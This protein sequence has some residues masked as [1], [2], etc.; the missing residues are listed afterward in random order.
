MLAVMLVSTCPLAGQSISYFV[1]SATGLDA[2]DGRSLATPWQTLANVNAR[3]FQPGDSILFKSGSSW[4]G[5]L[6][7]KG[8]GTAG[9]P[10]VIDMYGGTTKPLIAGNGIVSTG[11]L[12]LLNQE[13]WE[14][15]N[16]EVT[17]DAAVGGDR[18]G[19]YV[20]ASEFGIVHHI[21]LKK[22]DVHDVKGLVGD[23]DAEKRTAGIGFETTSDVTVPTRFD[24]LLIEGCN[25][26]MIDNTGIF[27]DNKMSGARTDYP[28]TGKWPA[29]KFTN[30]R[31][32]GNTIHHIAKN[33][34]IMRFLEQGVVEN[35]V[36]FE[37][38]LKT[39]GNTMFTASCDGTVFQ[40]NEG[41]YNRSVGADGSMYDAD[42]RSP[43]TI[44]QYSYSHDNAHGLFWTCTVQEDAN[45][46]CRYNV[47]QNDKG[48]IFCINYPNTSVACYNNTVYCGSGVS[49]TIISERNV[50]TGTRSYTFQ[51]NV[52]YNFS[53]TAK[54]DFR[55][56]GYTRVIDYNV[57]F[58][59]HPSNEP[60]DAHKLTSDPQFVNPGAAST[61]IS[62]TDG[63][64]LK[65]TSPCINSGF[66]VLA[67]GG[68]DFWG[69]SVPSGPGTDRGAHEFTTTSVG[70]FDESI[71]RTYQLA[72]NYPNPFNPDTN[73]RFQLAS[74]QHV[75][76][77][78]FDILGRKVR[79]LKYGVETVG[80]HTAQWDGNDD[81]GARVSSGVYLA[82][83]VA[84]SSVSITKMILSR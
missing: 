46:I 28:Q 57:F 75:E 53:P 54:Y 50:N 68:K 15:N 34:M 43:N 40:F 47:S 22:L 67:N 81:A 20:A 35:N 23:G 72:Q 12:Y 41:Y 73:I 7:P 37:T 17:N 9:N 84:G 74:T 82:R 39:T 66:T 8:S 3:T 24:D 19:V 2:N 4:T 11:T 49:P 52:I 27:T 36:C 55:T 1:D 83:L 29:R 65:P 79:R 80:V 13:W 5:Q 76:L 31:V 45:V 26:Y 44:W 18:R 60:A 69:N 70:D 42:L 6:W 56:S 16:L 61:G 32:R 10:I 59:Y 62:S 64:K 33:A 14:I 63:Y 77:C 78:V 51:N 25:I 58:G 48:I 21:Y 71:G 38:A 30:V